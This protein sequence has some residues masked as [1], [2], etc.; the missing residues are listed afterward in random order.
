MKIVMLDRDGVINLDGPDHVR[1]PEEW[2]PIAGSLEAIAKLN[3]AGY[4]VVVITNQSGIGR[5][6]FDI[7]TLHAIHQKMHD[8]LSQHGGQIDTVLFCPHQPGDD[9]ECRKPRPGMLHTLAER[10]RIDLKDVPFVGD[11]LRDLQ[12][13]IAV[14]ARPVLVKTGKGSK[15]LEENQGMVDHIQVHDD[16]AGFVDAYLKEKSC[17]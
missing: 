17:S 13:G 12:A 3:K 9:C 16:L 5:G 15:T 1:K 4:R 6:Y 10:L 2:I 14:G 11:A 7:E 8:L